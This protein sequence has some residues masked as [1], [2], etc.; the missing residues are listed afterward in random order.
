MISV[1]V[2]HFSRYGRLLI[3]RVFSN[4][5]EM[6]QLKEQVISLTVEL[7]DQEK[8]TELLKRKLDNERREFASFEDE[9]QDKNS[10]QIKVNKN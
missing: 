7:E 2:S 3:L 5:E 6:N 1:S 10:L 4:K 8:A 9:L